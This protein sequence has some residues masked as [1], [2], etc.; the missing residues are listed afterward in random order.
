MSSPYGIKE[1]ATPRTKHY[2]HGVMYHDT[3]NQQ[4]KI[5]DSKSEVNTQTVNVANTLDNE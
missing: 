3:E 5:K 2:V 4:E 1:E